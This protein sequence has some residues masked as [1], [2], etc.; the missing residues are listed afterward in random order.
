MLVK[1]ALLSVLL[2][3]AVASLGFAQDKK[4]AVDP[5][6]TWRWDFDS[7]GETIKNVL[8]LESS[9]DGKVTGTL[10]ARDMKMEV[11]DGKIKD[12]KLSF[13]IK[14]ETPRSFKVVF[15]GKVDSDKVEGKADASS[16][17]GEMELP[18]TAKRSVEPS[19][20]VGTWKLKV[21]LPDSQV[22]QPSLN[23]VL[24]DNKLTASMLS[25]DGKT[26]EAKKVEIKNN[27]LHFEIDS[28]YEGNDLHVVYRGRAYG[29]KLKGMLEYTVDNNSG[30]LEFAGALQPEKK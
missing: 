10:A 18:W 3:T 20:L 19:D 29:S 30:E 17:Q 23:V 12:G 25:D 4:V 9:Q 15:E 5:S 2:I 22:L 27:M 21:T 8:K 11:I 16:D 26:A 24:K 6:G 1:R 14:M 28:Q 7:N 13:Q